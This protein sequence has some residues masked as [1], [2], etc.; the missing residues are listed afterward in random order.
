MCTECPAGTFAS[1]TGETSCAN[2]DAGNFVGQSGQS[3][4]LPCD[5]GTFS[6]GA[7]SECSNC[8]TGTF[9][10]SGEATC[11]SCPAGQTTTEE[12]QSACEDCPPGTFKGEGSG[13]C[14]ECE[15]GTFAPNEGSSICLIASAGSFVGPTGASEQT[16][17]PAGK[18][19]GSGASN[20]ED[21]PL[22]QFAD[23]PGETSCTLADA[24]KFVG[25]TGASEQT[26]CPAGH[27]S[28][29]GATSCTECSAGQYASSPGQTVCTLASAGSFVGESGQSEQLPCDAGRFSGSGTSECANC[30][31]GTFSSAGDAFCEGCPAGRTT[32]EAGS[33]EC[34]LCPAG[35]AKGAGSSPCQDCAVSTFAAEAGLSECRIADAGSFVATTGASEQTAC[36]PGTSS[37]SGAS[38]CTECLAGSFAEDPGS[39]SCQQAS[40]G[41]FVA[42][43]GA[44]EENECLEGTFAAGLGSTACTPC[45]SGTFQD[46]DAQSSCRLA[47]A[48][49]YVLREGSAQQRSC[50]A[51]RFSG[52]GALYC[53]RCAAGTWSGTGAT[54][55]QSADAG[56]I[57]PSSGHYSFALNTSLVFDGAIEDFDND[58]FSDTITAIVSEDLNEFLN[59]TN[60][61]VLRVSVDSTSRR[62]LRT[63]V[64]SAM[65]RRRGDDTKGCAW[66]GETEHMVKQ[67]CTLR[68]DSG[69]VALAACECSCAASRRLQVSTAST[70][71]DYVVLADYEAAPAENASEIVA[72]VRLE[73]ISGL[74]QALLEGA[75][76]EAFDDI[77][78][79][80][81]VTASVLEVAATTV[82]TTSI[83]EGDDTN[84]QIPCPAGKYSLSGE[85]AC[86]E[87]EQG[88]YNPNVGQSTCQ[89]AEI[90]KFVNASGATES[91]LCPQGSFSAG[92]GAVNCT[93]CDAGRYAPDLGSSTCSLASA[94]SFVPSRGASEQVEC[95]P[96][97]FAAGSG[98]TACEDCEPG[99]Y[100]DAA[101]ESSCVLASS[102]FFVSEEGA[103]AQVPCAPGSISSTGASEC[104]LCRPR[105]YQN[106]PGQAECLITRAGHFT[107]VSGA[108]AESECPTGTFSNGNALECTGCELG[109]FSNASRAGECAL[110]PIPTTTTRVGSV[111]CDAC[112]Q[113]YYWDSV[114]FEK[115]RDTL[116]D[117]Q[118]IDCCVHC[119]DACDDDDEDKC[120]QCSSPGIT[121]EALPVRRGF[122]R[123]TK[124]STKVYE[125]DLVRACRGGNSTEEDDQCFR[126]HKGA[127]C[128]ACAP[129]FELNFFSDKCT[130]CGAFF[131]ISASP[132]GAVTLFCIIVVVSFLAYRLID[133]EM[134]RIAKQ[135]FFDTLTGKM[136]VREGEKTA[137]SVVA[138]GSRP[139]FSHSSSAELEADDVD[140]AKED[141]AIRRERLR[142]EAEVE[143]LRREREAE[144][145][146]HA[147]SRKFW[148]AIM[149]KMKI[150]LAVYQI[151]SST[152]WSLPQVEFP[153][154]TSIVLK[155]ATVLQLNIFQFGSSDCL[156]HLNYFEELVTITVFPFCLGLIGGAL[157]VLVIALRF[158][159]FKAH[160]RWHVEKNRIIYMLLLVGYV[161][162]P[163]CSA[164]TFRY[165]SCLRY[166]RGDGRDDLHALAIDPTIRCTS[167]RYKWWFW[168]VLL[169]IF[170]WPVGFPLFIG[171]VLFRYRK[172][173]DPDVGPVPEMNMGDA[174][175][176]HGVE[177]P[178]FRRAQRHHK[179]ILTQLKKI[180]I[181]DD[182]A[183]LEAIQFLWEEY[184][185]R[186]MYFPVFETSRRIFLTGI[187]TMFYPG[188]SSQLVLGLFGSLVSHRVFNYFQPYV[189]EDD[190]V[191][192]EVAQTQLVII[193]LAALVVYIS[194]N[195][196]EREGIFASNAFGIFLIIVYM[197]AFA[198]ACY[199]ILVDIFG[200][201][202]LFGDIT[203][204]TISSGLYSK[205][206]PPKHSLEEESE[207]EEEGLE[208]SFMTSFAPSDDRHSLVL[209]D[210]DSLA[211]HKDVDD[212]VKS[213]KDED[214]RVSVS[215]VIASQQTSLDEA[216]LQSSVDDP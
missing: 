92:Q 82:E 110:C 137:L 10:D 130:K 157:Y 197:T 131:R 128:G 88:S 36:A 163:G 182:D 58:A 148:T 70:T 135:A 73:F 76:Q 213:D 186:C 46:L 151:S 102:G 8:P 191:V 184:V 52:S 169:S 48:G 111:F 13:S 6:G 50:P 193:F 208:N 172:R 2:A 45:E 101:G 142:R 21:C 185:P 66:V 69:M 12:G 90:G 154:I 32:T 114:Y 75:V 183:D 136:N 43:Q 139:K 62:A 175:A 166:D 150:V 190:G 106:E 180:E 194:D 38:E 179:N 118:C 178:L 65:W 161:A 147:K 205:T 170:V 109:R 81:D 165:F 22:G 18:I 77:G 11:Q 94:G 31:N 116:G 188:S 115:N 203:F 59:V 202:Q 113:D 25:S 79:S 24:G 23:S 19:S 56:S 176:G 117:D 215:E 155:T 85:T 201:E 168:Y 34:S 71:T 49:S 149:S 138:K 126:G 100:Q 64:D 51:G 20:C 93:L 187:L 103:T 141:L 211:G 68:D 112:Q 57:A 181:R 33:S 140:E 143:R 97:S 41:S 40:A 9:S 80:V 123:A 55:C 74:E 27:F 47:D 127:L 121:L 171:V 16:P 177:A 132:E 105:T 26:D 204:N 212:E 104:Q 145:R 96:G 1:S 156:V 108:S 133:W 167:D 124:L 72:L 78:Y 164:Y 61:R 99:S 206:T 120:L 189:D 17:C 4:Q 199:F 196:E 44:S 214:D 54:N 152:P 3:E 84:E 125:C 5:A 15:T 67:R 173:V 162:L 7:S 209:G 37:G 160:I 53:T 39:Q 119:E 86:R 207:D 89:R 91:N 35:K 200:Y 60:V 14:T 28:G 158:K 95:L 146:E 134:L 87:C 107:N 210:R 29:S 144:E 198:V 98:T 42:F 159:C 153:S 192:S 216:Q 83:V 195:L 63:C 174:G 129:G 30:A 122:W